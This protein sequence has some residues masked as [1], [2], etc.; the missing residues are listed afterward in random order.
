M[1]HTTSTPIVRIGQL[2]NNAIATV[3]P[4]SSTNNTSRSKKINILLT[5]IPIAIENPTRP[6]RYSFFHGLKKVKSRIR[7]DKNFIA[8]VLS[9]AKYSMSPTGASINQNLRKSTKSLIRKNI[10][11]QYSEENNGNTING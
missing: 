6:S 10:H 9:D 3:S 7:R 8:A 5:I 2:I 11:F 1:F 4:T